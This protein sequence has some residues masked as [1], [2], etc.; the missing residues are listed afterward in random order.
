MMALLAV[1]VARRVSCSTLPLLRPRSLTHSP[2]VGVSSR[3]LFVSAHFMRHML[4]LLL[5][6]SFSLRLLSQAASL[7][8][9]VPTAVHSDL[10][11]APCFLVTTCSCHLDIP[12][13]S[14]PPNSAHPSLPRGR[15]WSTVVAAC[16]HS[17]SVWHQSVWLMSLAHSLT[18]LRV[19]P[20]WTLSSTPSPKSSSTVHLFALAHAQGNLSGGMMRDTTLLLLATALGVTFVALGLLRIRLVSVSCVN[21]FTAQSV[22]PGPASGTRGLGL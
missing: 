19:L 13:A 16:H 17:L 4:A 20:L 1:M 14:L 11:V 12:Q 18:F 9:L 6:T 8:T 2:F 21:S 5:W 10:S 7:F 15:D 3:A 22:P